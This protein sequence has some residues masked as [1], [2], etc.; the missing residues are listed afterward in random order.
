MKN[1]ILL[2]LCKN[3]AQ[4]NQR[5][6][7]I[8]YL[9]KVDLSLMASLIIACM[10]SSTKAA[11]INVDFQYA[12]QTLHTGNDGI[13]SGTGNYW[14]QCPPG[15]LLPNLKD[16]NNNT[17]SISIENQAGAVKSDTGCANDLQSD[18]ICFYSGGYIYIRNLDPAKSYSI[19]I[20]SSA[21]SM[22]LNIG[23]TRK[24]WGGYC[25]SCGGS[26]ALPGLES[27]HYA[28]VANLMPTA[29]GV[30]NIYVYGN[31]FTGMR[32]G[33][34]QIAEETGPIASLVISPAGPSG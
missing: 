7:V 24:T 5:S 8:R 13:L 34:I 12:D 32:V 6:Q 28:R 3:A 20:Y 26:C 31:S 2:S 33:G 25:G 18:S 30:I 21:D 15:V 10:A 27:Y 29:A 19:A 4:F 16:E 14:N 11:V 9:S 23:G 1:M 17:T 22:D